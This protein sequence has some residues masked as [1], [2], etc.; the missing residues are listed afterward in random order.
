MKVKTLAIA[1]G[2]LAAAWVFANPLFMLATYDTVEFDV[3]RDSQS[4]KEGDYLVYST[5]EVFRNDDN[6]WIAKWNSD[7][8]DAKLVKG[9][10]AVCGAYGFRLTLPLGLSTKRNLTRC[11]VTPPVKAP[12]PGQ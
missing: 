6:S 5:K 1:A 11:D 3:S 12:A 10:H 9:S 2:G 4:T 8:L 7:D